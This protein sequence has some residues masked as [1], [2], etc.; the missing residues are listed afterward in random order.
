MQ[1]R[2]I[3]LKDVPDYLA[4][5]INYFNKYIR[6][7]L[8]EIRYGPQ[9][10]GFDR[11]DLDQWVMQNKDVVASVPH[12]VGET[13]WDANDHPASINGGRCTTSLALA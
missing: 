8:P 1:P 3:R 10:V 4:V 5:N 6:P 2:V 9:M 12:E 11:V 13:L 7:H